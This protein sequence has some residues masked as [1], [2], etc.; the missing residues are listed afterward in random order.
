MLVPGEKP[1]WLTIAGMVIITTSLIM[2]Y[3]YGKKSSF[4]L[5]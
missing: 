3:K 2:F 1:E 4:K 5:K